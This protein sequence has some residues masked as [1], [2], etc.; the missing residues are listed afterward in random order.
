VTPIV[1]TRFETVQ[2]HWMWWPGAGGIASA[3]WA[4]SRRRTLG[5]RRKKYPICWGLNLPLSA[6]ADAVGA[7]KFIYCGD[8]TGQRNVRRHARPL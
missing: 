2:L 1:K 8:S 7:L 4:F 3:S 6:R 5:V